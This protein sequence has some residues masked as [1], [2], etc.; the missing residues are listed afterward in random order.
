LQ[1]APSALEEHKKIVS[2]LK[3]AFNPALRPA[4]AVIE[5]I[6][7]NVH[8]AEENNDKESEKK[9]SK[10]KLSRSNTAT[11]PLPSRARVSSFL[12]SLTR[13]NELSIKSKVLSTD[14][15]LKSVLVKGGSKDEDSMSTHSIG[16]IQCKIRND[17]SNETN[18]D[19][20]KN[21]ETSDQ[22]LCPVCGLELGDTY[23]NVAD[24]NIML[25]VLSAV[26]VTN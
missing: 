7:Q 9:V 5:E 16:D 4:V 12:G 13:I 15:L 25:S 17:N 3:W 23:L 10:K 11:L 21:D 22:A 6:T 19:P 20:E 8:A 24:K 14:N 18:D 1:V 26:F 2:M